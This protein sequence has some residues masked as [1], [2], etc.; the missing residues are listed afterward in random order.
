M[1]N[2]IVFASFIL[3]AIAFTTANASQEST[4]SHSTTCSAESTEKCEPNNGHAAKTDAHHSSGKDWTHKRLEQ[5]AAVMPQPQ[6]D[7]TFM[8]K[9]KTVKLISPKFLNQIAGTETKLEWSASENAEFYHV[10]VSQDAGFNNRSMY[11]ANEYKV[12]GTTFELKNLQPNTKYFWRVAG[13][14][15]QLKPSHSKSNFVVSEFST[16]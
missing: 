16:K 1:K 8:Q 6:Q 5:V 15:T 12:T 3:C 7:P 9:P 13:Y 11:V 14:N 10:Q 4:T 2:Y